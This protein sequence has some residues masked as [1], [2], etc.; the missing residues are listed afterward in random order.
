M[1]MEWEWVDG[2]DNST[3][4]DSMVFDIDPATKQVSPIKDQ[5]LVSGENLS[6]FIR[7]Q[8][9]RYFDGVDLSEKNIQIIYMT[10]D[11]HSD[12]NT[13]VCVERND[14]FIRF[15]WVVPE[16]ASYTVGKLS[17]SL[18]FVGS[19][20]VLK[21]RVTDVEVFDGLNGGEIIPEPTEKVW[22]IELQQRCD[23]VLNQAEAA[24]N[25]AKTSENKSK[26]Y[27]DGVINVNSQVRSTA[28]QFKDSAEQVEKNRENIQ[29]NETDIRTLAGRIDQMVATYQG[30]AEG[31]IA[32]ARIGEDG[33]VYPSLG[34]AIRGQFRL[35]G[36]Y[37]DKDG[38]ICQR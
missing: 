32:D 31:E 34:A 8:M 3:Y 10:E 18:E 30:S 7:F 36:L 28:E 13:A 5:T 14:D 19:N 35:L 6:Q 4:T 2:Y 20:Y 23:Y 9:P 27:L 21:T 24:K 37:V 25:A 1:S 12:I 17:F 26:E 11:N 38:Y 15:G 29:T 33:T 16:A 22:Y